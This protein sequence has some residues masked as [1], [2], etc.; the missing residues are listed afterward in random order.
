MIRLTALLLVVVFATHYGTSWVG[1]LYHNP[2]AATKAWFYTAQ[3]AKGCILWLV[4]AVL[5]PRGAVSIP[6]YAVCA[7]GFFEDAQVAG[8]RIAR[9]IESVPVTG[10]W[11]GVCGGN[12]H[13]YGLLAGLI[14]ASCAAY[15]VKR[16]R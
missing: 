12:W 5:A 15:G 13:L 7:W 8:C 3:G 16:G 4:V 1:L 14:A 9:G 2:I 11:L 10:V 6:V